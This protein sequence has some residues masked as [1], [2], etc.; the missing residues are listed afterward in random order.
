MYESLDHWTIWRDDVWM[1]GYMDVWMYGCMDV[2]MYTCMYVCLWMVY[3]HT[4]NGMCAI[5]DPLAL[6]DY[7]T[8]CPGASQF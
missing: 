1:Y 6:V 7:W 3:G 4:E 2:Y 5:S 8:A